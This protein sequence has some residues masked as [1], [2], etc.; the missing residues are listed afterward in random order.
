MGASY[1]EG[2]ALAGLRP[3]AVLLDVGFTLTFWDGDRIAAHAARA[4]VTVAPSDIERAESLVRAEIRELE[5]R[6][7]RTH[8]DGGELF[9]DRVF[10][11]LLQ[12]SRVSADS[13]TLERACRLIHAEH[14]KQNVWRRVGGGNRDALERLRDGG[15]R[16]AVV[17]NSEGT[18]EAML[19]EVGLRPFFETVVDSNVV[20]SVKPD[21]SIY[22]IALDRLRLAPADAIMVGDSPTADVHGAHTVGLSAALIDPLDLYP[23]VPAPRFRDLAAFATALLAL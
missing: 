7:T 23:W 5:T 6:P 9:L 15:L 14:L 11:R 3:Q 22:R 13:E 1:H 18:V 20:G 21:A 17:S 19:E 12:L 2:R 8:D 4:G 10:R 16:L